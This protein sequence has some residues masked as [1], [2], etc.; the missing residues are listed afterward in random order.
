VF[1]LDVLLE[2]FDVDDVFDDEAETA[3]ARRR[4]PILS[5]SALC[6]SI[7]LSPLLLPLLPEPSL[8][9]LYCFAI[10]DQSFDLDCSLKHFEHSSAESVMS[11]SSSL[12]NEQE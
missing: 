8:A 4:P 11:M 6:D 2:V 5:T 10:S 7:G 3:P 12:H 9:A 1:S